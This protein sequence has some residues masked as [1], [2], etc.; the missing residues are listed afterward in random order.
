MTSGMRHRGHLSIVG[1]NARRRGA[2]RRHAVLR[3]ALVERRRVT[4]TLLRAYMG[5]VQEVVA[6]QRVKD[7]KAGDRVAFELLL[8][9]LIEPG[10]RF[11]CAMLHDSQ[12]AED[13]VQEASLK[14]WIK[15]HQLREGTEIR[16]WFF[17]IVANQCRTAR[18]Q[19]WWSVLKLAEPPPRPSEPAVDAELGTDLR[20]AIRRLEHRDRTVLILYFFV[21]LPLDEIA[22]ATG[23]TTAAVRGQLYRAVQKLRPALRVREI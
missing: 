14:A 17:G 8:E 23:T 15:L 1:R 6:V 18:R 4:K 22:A 10:Y 12:A 2:G 21:D 13:A 20:T 9:P 7:A 16:P 5:R 19:R 3:P 11:A